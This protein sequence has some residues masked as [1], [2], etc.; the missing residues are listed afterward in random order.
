[1]ISNLF[2]CT[3][4]RSTEFIVSLWVSH[5]RPLLEYSSCV[6]N[7]KYLCDATICEVVSCCL[8]LV[9][10]ISAQPVVPLVAKR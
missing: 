5:G 4:C 7:V 6:W 10:H 8:S 9:V 1:M 3:V 2:E